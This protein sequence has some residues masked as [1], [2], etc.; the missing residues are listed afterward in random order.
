MLRDAG[1]DIYDEWVNHEIPFNDP[2]VA[3]G[4]RQ[5]RQHP[6]E[7]EVRQRRLR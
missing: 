2:K 1:A 5:R 7:P 4:A 3:D 6:E